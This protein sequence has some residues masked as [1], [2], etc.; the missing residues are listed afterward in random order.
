MSDIPGEDVPESPE[1]WHID[2]KSDVPES[3]L[4]GL[5]E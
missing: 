5:D 1:N 2:N 3:E 4:E